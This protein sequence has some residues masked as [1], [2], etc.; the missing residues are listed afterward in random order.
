[1]RSPVIIGAVSALAVGSLL[2]VLL[3]GSALS[4]PPR[5]P[6]PTAPTLPPIAQPSLEPTDS[7]VPTATGGSPTPGGSPSVGSPEPPEEGV[8]LGDQAPTIQLPALGG[9]TFDTSEY[10]GT[11]LWINFMATWCPQCVDELPMM[12]LMQEQLGESMNI[13]LVDVGEDEEV[14]ADFIEALDVDLPVGIDRQADVQQEW[15]VMVLPIHFFID[16][17]GVVR[18]T[19]IGGA[20]RDIFV[21]H[22]LNVVPD[23][24]LD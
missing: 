12:Q 16:E 6:S 17:E 14:V 7:P 8:D 23:A 24:E 20:P 1:M 4:Q 10:A 18:S 15:G 13:V 19:L 3:L 21:E 22:V 11:P 5:Q 9:G 2:L